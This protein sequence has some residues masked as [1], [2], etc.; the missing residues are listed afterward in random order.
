MPLIG[1]P[2]DNLQVAELAPAADLKGD[3]GPPGPKGPKGLPGAGPPVLL[4]RCQASPGVFAS[5]PDSTPVEVPEATRQ[6]RASLNQPPL[7]WAVASNLYGPASDG[8]SGLIFSPDDWA[9][10][11]THIT[12]LVLNQLVID[13]STGWPWATRGYCGPMTKAWHGAAPPDFNWRRM[14]TIAN[15]LLYR[16]VGDEMQVECSCFEFARSPGS[17]WGAGSVFWRAP[18]GFRPAREHRFPAVARYFKGTAAAAVSECQIIVGTDGSFSY[19]GLDP[20]T[21]LSFQPANFTLAQRRDALPSDALL[22]LFGLS[23]VRYR[24]QT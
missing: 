4:P 3:Q 22:Y 14:Q 19:T 8:S 1:S 9:S 6:A 15:A 16:R 7:E 12:N 20:V 2:V 17:D 18:P 24:C 21:A 11:P 5:L 13:W 23:T 10:K